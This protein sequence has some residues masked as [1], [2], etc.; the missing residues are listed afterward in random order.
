M[1]HRYALVRII[2]K[3]TDN[4]N[5]SK[6]KARKL[7]SIRGGQRRLTGTTSKPVVWIGVTGRNL[8]RNGIYHDSETLQKVRRMAYLCQEIH[9]DLNYEAWVLWGYLPNTF[10]T[11]LKKYSTWPIGNVL[12][13]LS[14]YVY[15]KWIPLQC[16]CACY[17]FA[18][19]LVSNFYKWLPLDCGTWLL[20]SIRACC[21]FEFLPIHSPQRFWPG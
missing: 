20:K 2:Y 1:F 21:W 13:F 9:G 5:V 15:T 17:I 10:Q 14:N 19:I 4:N 18:N 7:H 11:R 3:L 16:S 6:V 12:F 8:M